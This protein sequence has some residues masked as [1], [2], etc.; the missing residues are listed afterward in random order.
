MTERSA[1]DHLIVAL[2]FDTAD[3]A[4]ALV[5]DLGEAVGFYKVG[6]Q[7]FV[8]AGWSYVERLLDQGKKV[9]LD[10]KIGDI[11]NT[12]RAALRNMPDE[13]AG[14]LELLTL[15]G[16]EA[17]VR[18]AKAG[19]RGEKPALLMVTLLSSMDGS[20]LAAPGADPVPEV[21]T[22][23][24]Q[25]AKRALE[26]GCEGLVASGQSVRE[27]REA[28]PDQAFLIVT[29]G[30]RPAGEALDEHKRSLTPYQAI[31]DGSDHLVVGRPIAKAEHPQASAAA[32]LSEIER[33]LQDRASDI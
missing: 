13:F 19:R 31:L 26:A 23:V 28:F 20:D 30:V 8:G 1:S 22:V 3:A 11:D 5:G 33:A 7:L 9:F 24:R 29:P 15:Q 14:A 25:R 18:A 12:V 21:S 6:W 17:T 2:D 16:N 10:L 27:L 32:I 4:D